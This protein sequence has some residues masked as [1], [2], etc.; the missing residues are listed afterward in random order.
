M[1]DG[2]EASTKVTALFDQ[3]DAAP[4]MG[5]QRRGT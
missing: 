1:I 5:Q 3:Q 4:V 2:R